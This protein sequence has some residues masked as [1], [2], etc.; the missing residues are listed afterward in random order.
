MLWPQTLCDLIVEE[1]NRYARRKRRRNWIDVTRSELYTFFGV[2]LAMGIHKLSDIWSRDGLLGIPEVQ[3]HMT[4]TRFWQI[5]FNLH[6]V[7]DDKVSPSDTGLT[8]KFQPVLDVLSSTFLSN[9][10]PGRNFL[11]MRPWLN[12]RAVLGGRCACPKNPLKR[13]LKYGAAAVRAVGICA[14]FECI[15]ESPLIR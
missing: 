11:W 6:V 9:Y 13:D 8:R 5:W 10:S 2:N 4:R 7:D 12:T 3:K 1:T 14:H 15:W